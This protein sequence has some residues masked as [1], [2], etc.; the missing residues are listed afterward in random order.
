MCNVSL[1]VFVWGWFEQETSPM[2]QWIEV[3]GV[4][5]RSIFP[6]MNWLVSF[7]FK[8]PSL[9]N[10]VFS[11]FWIFLLVLTLPGSVCCGT[12]TAHSSIS[13]K[14]E[15]SLRMVIICEG[16]YCKPMEHVKTY[17]RA[18]QYDSGK[19]SSMDSVHTS[20]NI[21]TGL[22]MGSWQ[23]EKIY[24]VMMKHWNHLCWTVEYVPYKWTKWC[25][26]KTSKN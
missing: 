16:T 23:P 15:P 8:G 5:K 7:L 20:N 6:K 9:D 12:G 19:T 21:W 24:S 2:F 25:I 10:P 18:C 26:S 17:G 14:N 22:E 4:S 11:P 1:H 13:N 3:S